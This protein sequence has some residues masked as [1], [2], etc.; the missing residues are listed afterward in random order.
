[1]ITIKDFPASAVTA[2]LQAGLATQP[3]FIPAPM[4]ARLDAACRRDADFDAMHAKLRAAKEAAVADYQAR[5]ARITDTTASVDDITFVGRETIP[6]I[7]ARFE[8][9]GNSLALAHAEFKK[10]CRPLLREF[11]EASIPVV[12]QAHH[13]ILARIKSIYESLG[14][15]FVAAEQPI[16]PAL[17]RWR[18]ML[19]D[20]LASESI[21]PPGPRIVYQALGDFA[22]CADAKTPPPPSSS[23]LRTAV[24]ISADRS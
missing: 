6:Q 20:M 21:Y 11:Y 14:V 9:P 2:N 13:S 23:S 24:D 18:P 1:M 16:T 3:A 4:K 10:E 12:N 7:E 15:P 17:G 22:V 5:C 19:K 8:P